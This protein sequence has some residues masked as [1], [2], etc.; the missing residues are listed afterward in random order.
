MDDV[1]TVTEE[2]NWEVGEVRP[3]RRLIDEFL[4][5]KVDQ[6]FADLDSDFHIA[7]RSSSDSFSEAKFDPSISTTEGD[8]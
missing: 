6:D 8:G 5:H 3:D 1:H 4:V 2:V 7:K